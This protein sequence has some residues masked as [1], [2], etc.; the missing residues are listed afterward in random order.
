VGDFQMLNSAFL[1][2]LILVSFYYCSG[3]FD[4]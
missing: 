4:Y 1:K 2:T 3:S